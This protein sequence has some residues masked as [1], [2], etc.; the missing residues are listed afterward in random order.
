MRP[1]RPRPLQ[2]ALPLG[3]FMPMASGAIG[4]LI[5]TD[6]AELTSRRS[7]VGK[8]KDKA[9]ANGATH[10]GTGLWNLMAKSRAIKSKT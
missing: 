1:C 4:H 5:A 9:G 6:S 3:S 10:R 2:A 7:E 8:M